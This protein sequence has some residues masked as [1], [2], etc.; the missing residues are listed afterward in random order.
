MV[1]YADGEEPARTRFRL[2]VVPPSE[3]EP[4]VDVLRHPLSIEFL[5][6]EEQEARA[7]VRQCLTALARARAASGGLAGL[8]LAGQVDEQGISGRLIFNLLTVRSENAFE[9][10]SAIGYRATRIHQEGAAPRVRVLLLLELRLRDADPRPWRVARAE[11]VG[12]SGAR[13]EGQVSQREPIHPGWRS[14]HLVVEAELPEKALEDVYS[15]TL[16]ESGGSRRVGFG[17]VRFP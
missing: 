4:R 15:L 5:Q 8:I 17:G 7:E 12:S 11:W 16:D 6:R 2:V 13:W 1:H 3:A 10:V 9:L 14:G